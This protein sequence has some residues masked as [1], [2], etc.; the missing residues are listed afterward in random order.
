[1]G[2]SCGA[3][4][5]LRTLPVSSH[6]LPPQVGQSPE[7]MGRTWTHVPCIH[8]CVQAISEPVTKC[9]P[10][11]LLPEDMQGGEDSV[12]PSL[13]SL[14]TTLA[15]CSLCRTLL[16]KPQGQGE[17]TRSPFTNSRQGWHRAGRRALYAVL[18]VAD[19]T[20]F[21]LPSTPSMCTKHCWSGPWMTLLSP[22][23]RR[24]YMCP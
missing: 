18:P 4:S 6:G 2:S 9:R 14:P 15:P 11:A 3:R 24:I 12:L 5:S 10:W 21:C 13:P 19:H 22:G 8:T 16:H 20:F 23:D 7:N 1:M 17:G